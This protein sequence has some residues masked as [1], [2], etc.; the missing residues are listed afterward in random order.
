M[1]VIIKF[2]LTVLAL[3][4]SSIPLWMYMGGRSLVS[5]EGFLQEFF[6]F[7]I[8]LWFLG[9]AQVVLWVFAGIVLLLIWR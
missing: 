4:V 9:G 2:L 7:G 1:N 3:M 8:G 6:V 5:P